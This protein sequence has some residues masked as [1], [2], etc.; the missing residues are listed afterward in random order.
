MYIYIYIYITSLYIHRTTWQV[1]RYFTE[2]LLD[3]ISLAIFLKLWNSLL[4]EH[5][6]ASASEGCNCFFFVNF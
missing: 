3:K 2:I 6:S 5:L 4:K 1:F